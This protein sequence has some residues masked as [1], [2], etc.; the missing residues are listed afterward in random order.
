MLVPNKTRELGWLLVVGR[1]VL[2]IHA[3]I[4]RR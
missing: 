4:A 1:V 2:Q 3:G